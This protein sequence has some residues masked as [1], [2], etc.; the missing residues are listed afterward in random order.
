MNTQTQILPASQPCTTPGGSLVLRG[1]R[2]VRRAQLRPRMRHRVRNLRV[3]DILRE[4]DR[5]AR[6]EVEVDVAVEEPRARVVR[7]AEN[8][9]RL[10]RVPTSIV[11][12]RTSG[13][14]YGQMGMFQCS[15]RRVSEGSRS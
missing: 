6:V 11:I 14:W 3:R 8:N 13:S 5:K 15:Q 7:D 2:I 10:A 9:A 4:H 12:E 1:K